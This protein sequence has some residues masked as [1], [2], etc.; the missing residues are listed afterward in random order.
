MCR[1][2]ARKNYG[3]HYQGPDPCRSRPANSAYYSD[4]NARL[5]KMSAAIVTSVSVR[6]PGCAGLTRAMFSSPPGIAALGT[7]SSAE[8]AAWSQRLPSSWVTAG[9]WITVPA[10]RQVVNLP[11]FKAAIA[12]RLVDPQ[13]I[14]FRDQPR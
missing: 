7:R 10:C 9:V 1:N 2:P 12:V 6:E 13:T 4:E 8:V 5:L 14:A 3:I 11:L